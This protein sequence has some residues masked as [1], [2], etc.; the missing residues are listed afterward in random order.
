LAVLAQPAERNQWR[1][2][3]AMPAGRHGIALV[4]C[5][6]VDVEG[7]GKSSHLRRG[8]HV[9]RDLAVADKLLE[10]VE[11]VGQFWI[12]SFEP[13]IRRRPS[14]SFPAFVSRAFD[15]A[16]ISSK[17]VIVACALRGTPVKPRS[18][19]LNIVPTLSRKGHDPL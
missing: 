12:S 17:A 19:R 3:H 13:T 14:I 6:M 8:N 7:D 4:Q 9:M 10:I 15:V 1:E 16:Q 18:F 2:E 5:R 11:R